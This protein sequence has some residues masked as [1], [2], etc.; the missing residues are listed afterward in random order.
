VRVAH[1]SEDAGDLNI[2]VNGQTSDLSIQTPGSLSNWVDLPP[3]NYQININPAGGAPA[4]QV[5]LDVEDGDYITIAVTG[6]AGSGVKATVLE[7][8]FSPLDADTARLS[9]FNGVA[10]SRPFDVVVNGVTQVVTLGYPGTLGDN[11]GFFVIEVPA[12]TQ[13]VEFV[14]SGARNDLIA[15]LPR[16]ALDGGDNYFIAIAGS[17]TDAPLQA[18]TASDV[19]TE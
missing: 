12:G 15:Y 10:Q 11:D 8:D 6:A 5:S 4:A 16:L 17:G 3:G 19:P 9:V 7:E 1:L 2:T 18:V 14:S 13:D